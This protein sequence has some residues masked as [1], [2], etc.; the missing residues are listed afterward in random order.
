[1]PASDVL[2]YWTREVIVLEGRG[3]MIRRSAIDFVIFYSKKVLPFDS[4]HM[5]QSVKNK[6]SDASGR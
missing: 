1:M 2:K 6:M 4:Q 5:V 3:E